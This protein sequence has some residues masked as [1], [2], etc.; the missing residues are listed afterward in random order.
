MWQKWASIESEISAVPRS[1]RQSCTFSTVSY[2]ENS[3]TKMAKEWTDFCYNNFTWWVA[4]ISLQLS[5]YGEY[6]DRCSVQISST[7]WCILWSVAN[8]WWLCAK[9]LS[10]FPFIHWH[11]SWMRCFRQPNTCCSS[12]LERRPKEQSRF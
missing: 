3:F 11:C 7:D 5:L 2:R 10:F 6:R 4:C 9:N 8:L 1:S 12:R